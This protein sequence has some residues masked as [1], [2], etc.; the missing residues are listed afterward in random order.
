MAESTWANIKIY[1][2]LYE[3]GDEKGLTHAQIKAFLD[4]T[5]PE[6][7]RRAGEE[8]VFAAAKLD[9][10]SGLQARVMRTHRALV[11]SWHGKD[12]AQAQK[13]LREIHGTA[14]ALHDALKSTGEQLKK[15]AKALEHYK[16]NVPGG[17]I[18]LN[19]GS[20][21]SSLYSDYGL[22][23]P[24]PSTGSS[25]TYS[26]PE[27]LTPP[28]SGNSKPS[29][30]SNPLGDILA[31]EHLRKLNNEIAE[32][33]MALPEGLAFAL[34]EVKPLDFS[35]HKADNVTVRDD[36]V[37]DSTSR[38]WTS[39]SDS[40]GGSGSSNTGG[41][42][43]SSPGPEQPGGGQDPGPG[44]PKPQDPQPQDPK[45]EDPKPQDP[46]PQDPQPQDPTPGT[47]EPSPQPPGQPGGTPETPGGQP[48]TPPVIGGDESRGT[49][50]ADATTTAP[51]PVTPTT[52]TTPPADY[53][54]PN[55]PPRTTTTPLV[56]PNMIGPDGVIGREGGVMGYG[57][58]GSGNP[59]AAPGV[60]R[61]TG[62][63]GSS[64]YP[65]APGG[66]GGAASEG[67]DE[68]DRQIYDPEG[69]AFVIKTDGTSPGRIGC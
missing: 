52:T 36:R 13:T 46:K 25:S 15:Y 64:M 29:V 43:S 31:R 4:N 69:D 19:G 40:P 3:L 60:L 20:T 10:Q 12:A 14:K 62:G 5:N 6:S 23:P 57:T 28:T 9:D 48:T 51:N 41:P 18:S 16:S 54:G 35:G 33:N 63:M 61:G 45:P 11:T 22:N 2:F 56:T 59:A 50:L 65:F 66:M 53:L 68:R 32:I 37:P 39:G 49:D 44:D 26:V 42:G 47:P 34:P 55:P 67:C 21:G 24:A 30:A 7:L 17:T 8:F 58:F 1:S 38:T 27:W